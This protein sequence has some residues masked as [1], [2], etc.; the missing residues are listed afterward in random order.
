[1]DIGNVVSILNL[2]RTTAEG[3][4]KILF[5]RLGSQRNYFRD[6]KREERYISK[7]ICNLSPDELI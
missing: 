5:H 4:H 3:I 2:I 1:M 7:T 6:E